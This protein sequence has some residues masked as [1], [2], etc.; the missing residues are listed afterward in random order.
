MASAVRKSPNCFSLLRQIEV[1]QKAGNKNNAEKILEATRF[2]MFLR[3]PF[4]QGRLFQINCGSDGFQC[5]VV[6]VEVCFCL[7]CVL[8]NQDWSKASSVA[9]AFQL[10]KL[11]AGAVCNLMS[12]MEPQ[13]Q[14]LLCESVRARGMKG[15]HYA[16]DAGKT[17]VQLNV[18]FCNGVCRSL[19]GG[20]FKQK[21]LECG[22]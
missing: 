10:G 15:C 17:V 6:A 5:V 8:C 19:G 22:A 3:R 16:R 11:E 14:L 7:S 18:L 4:I 12:N 1:L 2:E 20:G 21:Q 9:K 13:I